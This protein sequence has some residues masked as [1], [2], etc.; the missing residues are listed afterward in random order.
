MQQKQTLQIAMT[1]LRSGAP[2]S[3][4]FGPDR[5]GRAPSLAMAGDQAPDDPAQ[6]CEQAAGRPCAFG[7]NRG[8]RRLQLLARRRIGILQHAEPG[9]LGDGLMSRSEST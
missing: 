7:M 2:P 9:L 3:G 5:I 4:G 6:G 1:A 8:D